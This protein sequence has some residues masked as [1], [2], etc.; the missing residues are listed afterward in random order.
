MK[1]DFKSINITEKNKAKRYVEYDKQKTIIVTHKRKIIRKKKRKY[2][3]MTE[4]SDIRLEIYRLSY[5]SF[6]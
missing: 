5:D 4:T 2:T 1:K 3:N 6:T